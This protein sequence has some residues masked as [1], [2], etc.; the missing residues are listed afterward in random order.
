MSQTEHVLDHA[1]VAPQSPAPD[2]SLGWRYEISYNAHGEQS[3]VRIPLT[4]EEA[5]HPKEGYVMPERTEHDMLS[6]DL[7]DM[8]RVH[9]ENEPDTAV[10]R[11]LVF[12]WDHPEIGSYAPDIAV[13]PMYVIVMPV[14][15]SL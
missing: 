1:T 8:L 13:V 5:R 12:E 15:A 9:V 3:A 2:W 6:D 4:P 7:S 11:K 14:A 10:F